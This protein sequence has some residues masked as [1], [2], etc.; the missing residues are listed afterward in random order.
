MKVK[1]RIKNRFV[2]FETNCIY[3][4]DKNNEHWR[5]KQELYSG[6]E[7][8]L[9]IGGTIVVEPRV[10]N[11][12][13]LHGTDKQR[14]DLNDVNAR[15]KNL[16]Q[17]YRDSEKAKEER[18]EEIIRLNEKVNE[19]EDWNERLR[20]YVD[21]AD[22]EDKTAQFLLDVQSGKI[23]ELPD[24]LLNLLF[25]RKELKQKVLDTKDENELEHLHDLIVDNE[26]QINIQLEEI[27]NED[28]YRRRNK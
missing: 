1:I 15:Y 20:T 28:K 19:L 24:E 16:L 25:R 12:V 8:L 3:I 7:M 9:E 2:E 6:L 11:M 4:I 26:S 21:L 10:S 18:E 5:I 14:A 27:T 17:Q 22:G 23:T 13:F